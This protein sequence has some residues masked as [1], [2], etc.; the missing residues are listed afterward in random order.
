MDY[1]KETL[2]FLYIIRLTDG[3]VKKFEI[4]LDAKSLNHIPSRK[5]D[6]PEWARLGYKKCTN[7]PLDEASH[8]FCPIAVNISG[9][10]DEFRNASSYE[11]AFVMVMTRE[12]DMSKNTTIQEGLSSL[13]GIY[14]VTSGCPVM[15]KLKP[16]VRFH[17]PFATLEESVFRIVGMYLVMQYYLKTK[18]KKPDW[19][20]KKL[21]EI[22]DNIKVV[23]ACMAERL[24]GVSVKDGNISAV[25]DL[26]ELASLVPI[27]INETLA[28]MEESFSAYLPQ[29]NKT[30][31]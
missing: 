7:C 16:L 26:D 17:M 25:E 12:R 2:D 27:L 11:N 31:Q 20:L 6:P 5:Y 15:E 22:Y 30:D 28:S 14:M 29:E 8:E 10:V 24:R 4:A 1:P 13:I 9:I 3:S 23:N 21:G 18:G 19:E